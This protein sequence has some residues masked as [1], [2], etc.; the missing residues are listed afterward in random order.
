[1]RFENNTP[2]PAALIPNAEARDRMSAV[3]I[4]AITYR[5]GE[6]GLDLVP[7]QR[8]LAL[9]SG[10]IPNDRMLLKEGVS[11][12]ATG[13][14]YAPGGQARRAQAALTVGD[15]EMKVTVFGTR[16]W[17][18]GFLA[19]DLVP[20]TP[21]PFERVAMTWKNAFGG[22]VLVPSSLQ[23]IDGEEAIMPEHPE[24]YPYNFDGTGFYPTAEH[25]HHK[26]LPLIEHPDQPIKRW[27]DRPEP[28]CFAPY[29]VYGG[30]RA[31]FVLRDNQ[32][33]D[34]SK[35]GLLASRAA[36]RGTFGE[37]VEGTRIALE[38]MRPRGALLAFTVPA[39]PVRF[40]VAAGE[41]AESIVP[42]LDAVDIDAEAAEVRFLYRAKVAYD[43]VQFED[44]RLSVEPSSR[45]P[46]VPF[47]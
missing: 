1:M 23:K 7:V 18:K 31:G 37:I 26:P 15:R 44:R 6:R 2:L 28:V 25:A 36:P 10:P 17:Q 40:D 9:S 27:D 22:T 45:F 21:L 43:L 3:V 38:G 14:V 39:P 12:C 33:I 35:A 30:L 4:A 13:F 5:I 16:V 42:L 32:T 24:G 29:P 20:S 41:R 46:P 11:V 47:G 8:P 34:T 19:G